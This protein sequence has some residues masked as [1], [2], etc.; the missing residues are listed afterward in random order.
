MVSREGEIQQF[1]SIWLWPASKA[2]EI[3]LKPLYLGYGKL[4]IEFKTSSRV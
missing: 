4:L 3:E 1:R 2:S